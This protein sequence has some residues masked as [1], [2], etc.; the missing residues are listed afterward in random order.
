MAPSS[1]PERDK[2]TAA[3]R[4]LHEAT[5]TF[6]VV[7]TGMSAIGYA[8]QGD[9]SRVDEQARGMGPDALRHLSLAAS[10]LAGICDATL[11]AAEHEQPPP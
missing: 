10:T 3:L 4:R 8:I 11:L 7:L 5:R 6:G 2:L 1:T 9:L